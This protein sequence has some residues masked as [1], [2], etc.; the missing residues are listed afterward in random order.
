MRIVI[1]ETTN[2]GASY[3]TDAE[4]VVVEGKLVEIR[5]RKN[6]AGPASGKVLVLLVPEGHKIPRGVESGEYGIYLRFVH[7]R[8]ARS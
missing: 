2:S 1:G 4:S 8:P 7:R 5:D 6:G 3:R